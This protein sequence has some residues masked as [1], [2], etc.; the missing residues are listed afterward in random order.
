MRSDVEVLLHAM[1]DIRTLENNDSCKAQ[2]MQ[3]EGS[4]IQADSRVFEEIP[5]INGQSLA[6]RR[7]SHHLPESATYQVH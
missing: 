1:V 5:A 7:N 2:R 6:D 4:M 3:T